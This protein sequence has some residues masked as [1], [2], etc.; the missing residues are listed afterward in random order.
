[1]VGKKNLSVHVQH[2]HS[3]PSGAKMKTNGPKREK[4]MTLSSNII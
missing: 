4:S 2:S 1:M 3:Y